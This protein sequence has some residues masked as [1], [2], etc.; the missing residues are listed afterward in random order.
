MKNPIDLHIGQR[1]RHRRWLV[2]LTQK[3][4]AEAVGIRFQQIQKYESGA[5]RISAAKL[6]DLAQALDVPAKYFYVGLSEPNHNPE[7]RSFSEDALEQKETID[8]IRAYYAMKEGPRRMLFELAKAAS[9]P[10]LES[11][12]VAKILR[13]P[14]AQSAA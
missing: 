4:L 10:E 11:D 7:G 6:W 3:Q 1:L 2:R 9:K 13:L 8:L 14:G 12:K 5:N